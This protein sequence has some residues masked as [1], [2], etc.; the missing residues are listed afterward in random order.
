LRERASDIPQ[1]A[2]FFVDRFSRKFGKAIQGI[3]RSTLDRIIKYPWP[4]NVRELQN[5]IERA[6]IL[7]RTPVLELAPDLLPSLGGVA[8][9][10]LLP[11]GE[12]GDARR[13]ESSGSAS[14]LEEV[15]RTHLDSV[16]TKTNGVVEGPRGAAI[17]LGLHPNTLRHRMKKLGLASSSYRRS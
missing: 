12:L 9:G 17:I 11:E 6:V 5:V 14:T 10:P 13:D 7:S 1:L 3:S 16:L 4:G 15:E 2:L 8:A